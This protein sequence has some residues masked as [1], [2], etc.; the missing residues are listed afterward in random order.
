MKIVKYRITGMAP[1]LMNNPESMKP[2]APGAGGTKSR[3][4]TPKAEAEEKCYRDDKGNLQIPAVAFR[5]ALLRAGTG[6]KIGKMTAWSVYSASVF[7][8]GDFCTL[9]NPSTNKPLKKYD[10]DTRRAVVQKN[11]V[12]RSRA[13][14]DK[15][16]CILILEVDDELMP[17]IDTL[18]EGLSLAGKIIGVL[19]FRIEKRGWFGKFK[20]ELME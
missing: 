3:I 2:A 8:V 10:I 6:R 9:L 13:R 18:T 14:V 5:A 11:G 16:S 17:N 4:P 19:D 12:L 20:A 1:I 15:W 7:H